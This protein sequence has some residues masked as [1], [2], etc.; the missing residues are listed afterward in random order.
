MTIAYKVLAFTESV[1]TF[2]GK[3]AFDIRFVILWCLQITRVAG[4]VDSEGASRD[5][6]GCEDDDGTDGE[7]N[8]ANLGESREN[9]IVLPPILVD[10]PPE[11]C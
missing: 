11:K 6:G 1:E 10:D 9:V 5:E 2:P 8:P 7:L 3:L 4:R